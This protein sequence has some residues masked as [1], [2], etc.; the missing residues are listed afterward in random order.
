MSKKQALLAYRDSVYNAAEYDV[1]RRVGERSF[2]VV[3]GLVPS[4]KLLGN[5]LLRPFKVS[6]ALVLGGSRP[7]E[8][9]FPAMPEV[10]EAL[11]GSNLGE[12]FKESWKLKEEAAKARVEGVAKLVDLDISGW[13]QKASVASYAENKDTHVV[14]SEDGA[15]I[16][17]SRATNASFVNSLARTTGSLLGR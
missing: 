13:W 7:E 3:G 1:Q 15:A 11:Q 5:A 14:F 6:T 16:D 4:L 17:V 12:A 2:P 8:R 9:D 10:P